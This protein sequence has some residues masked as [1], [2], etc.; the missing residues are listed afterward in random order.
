M[1]SDA[2]GVLRLSRVSDRDIKMRG[3]QILVDGEHLTDLSYGRTQE[4][5]LA[6]GEHTLVATNTVSTQ[7]DTFQVQ[8]GRTV[9]YETANVLTG[10]GGVMMSILGIGPYRVELKRTE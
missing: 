5:P 2:S 3:L 7:R 9:A 4:F 1:A 10:V 6:P 8:P